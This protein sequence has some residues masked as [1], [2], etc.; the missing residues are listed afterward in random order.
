V[1]ACLAVAHGDADAA[2]RLFAA[3]HVLAPPPGESEV[4]FEQDLAAGLAEARAALGEQAARAAWTLGS[5][6]PL[7]AARAQLV[8]QLERVSSPA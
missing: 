6:L 3:A 5:A 2:V 4:P 7:A 1:G 8:E